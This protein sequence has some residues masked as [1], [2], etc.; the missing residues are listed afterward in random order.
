[1]F[2]IWSPVPSELLSSMYITLHV[3]HI[4]GISIFLHFWYR[5]ASCNS[6]HRNMQRKKYFYSPGFIMKCLYKTLRFV[7]QTARI[8]LILTKVPFVCFHFLKPWIQCNFITHFPPILLGQVNLLS[9][10]H[11]DVFTDKLRSKTVKHN[12]YYSGC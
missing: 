10:Y 7:W 5:F 1:M 12:L 6:F 9:G 11:P 8:N 2:G 4:F 3:L